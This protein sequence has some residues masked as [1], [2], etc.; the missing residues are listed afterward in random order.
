MGGYVGGRMMAPIA[1]GMITVVYRST[2]VVLIGLTLFGLVL[3]GVSPVAR[4]Q[5]FP[6]ALA[7]VLVAFGI[8]MVL[9]PYS[10]TLAYPEAALTAAAILL[11]VAGWKDICDPKLW[12]SLP[13]RSEP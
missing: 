3:V 2:Y 7:T 12:G 5:F 11:L 1:P 9:F 4:R 6:R 8:L 10:R 13:P